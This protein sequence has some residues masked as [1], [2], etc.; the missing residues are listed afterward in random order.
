VIDQ[1]GL[2]VSEY[3]IGTPPARIRFH[4]RSRLLAA[5]SAATVIVEAGRRSGALAVAR[6]AGELGRRTLQ[7]ATSDRDTSLMARWSVYV[8]PG[9]CVRRR[10]ADNRVKHG[11]HLVHRDRPG[12]RT[13]PV[14]NGS[15]VHT[16]GQPERRVL[17]SQCELFTPHPGHDNWPPVVW[18]DWMFVR[19]NASGLNLPSRS[20]LTT[21]A[22]ARSLVGSRILR[23]DTIQVFLIGTVDVGEI[24]LNDL[25]DLVR[26]EVALLVQDQ[27]FFCSYTGFLSFPAEHDCFLSGSGP[28]SQLLV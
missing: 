9:F 17:A 20:S 18:K 3:P 2:L 22:S 13:E 8:Q 25:L 26:A 1:G 23:S 12:R 7:S 14:K 6:A 5:L 10:R 11:E 19:S 27:D 4:A 15:P 28:A 24:G 21:K 16:R